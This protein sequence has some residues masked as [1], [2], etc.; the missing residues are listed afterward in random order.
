MAAGRAGLGVG[1]RR[2]VR[3]GRN[4]SER[5]LTS[6]SRHKLTAEVLMVTLLPVLLILEQVGAVAPPPCPPAYIAVERDGTQHVLTAPMEDLNTQVRLSL[7]D[8]TTIL[9]DKSTLDEKESKRATVAASACP[10]AV[11]EV[12]QAEGKTAAELYSAALAWVPTAFKSAKAVIEL[13]D[14]DAGRVVLKGSVPWSR[15]PALMP[16]SFVGNVNFTVTVEVKDGRYRYS[17][18]SFNAVF[19]TSA[20]TNQ[21]SDSTYG[22][23]TDAPKWEGKMVSLGDQKNWAEHQKLARD[24]AA[25]LA[26]SLK[27]AIAKPPEN[28]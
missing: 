14:K 22:P 17:I 10:I 2:S 3:S 16:W 26:A 12:V 20:K 27:A 23:I 18:D 15:T 25:S 4:L 1:S 8:G 21:P 6:A 9:M 24:T 11:Q 19:G 5:T 28:W 13:Q 7:P